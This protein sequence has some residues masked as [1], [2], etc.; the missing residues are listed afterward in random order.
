MKFLSRESSR[1]DQ[2]FR[3]IAC[4]ENERP[5][6]HSPLKPVLSVPKFVKVW[7]KDVF[8]GATAC[9][10]Q[11]NLTHAKTQSN[12]ADI[13]SLCAFVRAGPLFCSAANW[14]Q[15]ARF[16]FCDL[17]PEAADFWPFWATSP[18]SSVTFHLPPSIWRR[19]DSRRCRCLVQ[20]VKEPG[21]RGLWDRG[22]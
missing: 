14:T 13:Q 17:C 16:I 11:S 2:F 4:P 5:F 12:C 6:Q 10:D 21:P 20:V 7:A 3:S 18:A 8:S 22:R 15:Y 19:A 1:P 9:D